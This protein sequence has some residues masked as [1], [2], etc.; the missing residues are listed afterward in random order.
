[1]TGIACFLLC[2]NPG[3]NFNYNDYFSVCCMC[4]V[5][6]CVAYVHRYMYVHVG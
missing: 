2:V 5:H 6:V 3:F 1:M 4:V